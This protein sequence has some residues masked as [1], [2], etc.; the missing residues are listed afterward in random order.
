MKKLKPIPYKSFP[1]SEQ[2]L[3]DSSQI[4]WKSQDYG[5]WTSDVSPSGKKHHKHRKYTKDFRKPYKFSLDWEDE[6]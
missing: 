5:T 4:F 6:K 2:K 3:R 1:A